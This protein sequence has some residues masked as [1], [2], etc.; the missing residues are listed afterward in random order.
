LGVG[1]KYKKA[2]YG[3]ILPKV[4]DFHQAQDLT[5]ETFVTA[6]LSIESLDA[7]EKVGTWLCGIA[8]NLANKWL[9]REKRDDLSFEGLLESTSELAH[10]AQLLHVSA[11]EKTPDETAEHAE[12]RQLLWR[13]LISLPDISSEVLILSYI[14]EMKSAEIAKFLGISRTAVTTRLSDARKRLKKEMV[15]MVESTIESQPLAEDFS[16]QVV[17]EAIK[18]GEGYLAD[19]HW[20]SAREQFQRAADVQGNY[21]PAYRGLGM[22]ARELIEEQLS[23]PDGTVDV[24]L[25]EEACTELARAYRLGAQDADT[26]RALAHLYHQF[27]R[28]E[29]YVDL[30][31]NFA[32]TTDDF[33]AGFDAGCRSIAEMQEPCVAD[34]KSRERGFRFAERAVNAHETVLKRFDGQITLADQLDSY[35]HV[36]DAYRKVGCAADWL[37]QTEH[38]VDQIGDEI[39]LMP[40]A[41]Y[42]RERGKTLRE[43][44]CHREAA[45]TYEAFIDWLQNTEIMDPEKQALLIGA[46]G[47]HLHLAP[48]YY[49]LG[50]HQKVEALLA[51]AEANLEAYF[52]ERDTVLA[53]I[54]DESEATRER[55]ER[56][57]RKTGGYPTGGSVVDIRR[58]LN[59]KYFIGIHIATTCL[60]LG[61]AEVGD[62]DAAIRLLN[63]VAQHWE[64]RRD[65]IEEK[66]MVWSSGGRIM[67]CLAAMMLKFRNDREASLEYLKRA[68][69]DRRRAARGS[70]KR[71]FE[72]ADAFESVRHDPEFLAVVNAPVVSQ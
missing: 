72:E 9:Y 45:H 64:Q 69:E 65:Y 58:W 56:I 70:I 4:R 21:A 41:L 55:L 7:P 60:A 8:R 37:E 15:R 31:W 11:A 54:T 19:G 61:C 47:D 26:V 36:F 35:F 2:V 46:Q 30:L 28:C 48:T 63:R 44:G 17:T 5:S 62:G 1:Q 51:E 3:V 43:W 53:S 13:C 59:R 24:T 25:I 29:E 32:M 52:T 40:R 16:E 50:E 6:Y 39:T 20:K 68:H 10:K 38:L 34:H 27:Q 42:T 66:V 67:A 49:Q 12:L 14:R 22:V 23:L 18:R 71:F 33:D 57:Y